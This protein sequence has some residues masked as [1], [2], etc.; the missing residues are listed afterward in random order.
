MIRF[1]AALNERSESQY[2]FQAA[3]FAIGAGAVR[4][5]KRERAAMP[6]AHATNGNGRAHRGWHSTSSMTSAMRSGIATF[7]VSP[8]SAA[9]SKHEI[10]C[11]H[12]DLSQ[13][14]SGKR[15]SSSRTSTDAIAARAR[16]ASAER[17]GV[18]ALTVALQQ[19]VAVILAPPSRYRCRG[20]RSQWPVHPSEQPADANC[21][22]GSRIGL[23][24]NG[25]R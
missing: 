3:L 17:A 2:S 7:C 14:R 9:S 6:A 20:R 8:S 22:Y 13:H 25:A 21:N 1:I 4:M 24:L 23:R 10:T 11:C 15:V 18:S 16:L 5:V 19:P 12:V